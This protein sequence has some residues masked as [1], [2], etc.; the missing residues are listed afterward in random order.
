MSIASILATAAQS[1][2]AELS[3]DAIEDALTAPKNRDMGDVA[4]PCFLL[5]KPLRKGP[6]MIAAAMLEVVTPL[7]E[8]DPA[9]ASVE[10]VGPYLNFRYDLAS[11]TRSVLSAAVSADYG[12]QALGAGQRIG[13]DFSSPNIAKPF[14][15][16]HLR[17]T[18]IGAA[19]ARIYEALGYEVVRINH[20]GDWGTQF[21]KLMVA[22]EKWGDRAVLEADPIQHLY[23]LYVR[24]HV[25]AKTDE[26]LNDEGR[27]WFKKLEDG[28]AQAK[29][30]WTE[31]RDLSMRE[32]E[33][34]YARLNVKFDHYWGEAFYNEMLEDVIADVEA[35]GL[36][37][38][39]E[40]ALVVPMTDPEMPPCLLRKQDGA[41][42]YATRDLAAARYRMEE[43]KLN[44]LLYVVGTAQTVHFRQVFEVVE[45]MGWPFASGLEHI[46]FGMILGMS[47]RKGTLVFLEQILDEG[48]A[49]VLDYLASKEDFTDEERDTI[50]E[51]IAIGAVVFSDLS[52]NRVVDYDFSWE[53]ML[54]GL[55]PGERGQTGVYLQYTNARLNSVRD[56][57]I[58]Q[59]GSVPTPSDD[60]YALLVEP[61]AQALIALL[62]AWPAAV[63]KAG[64]GAEPAVISRYALRLAEAFNGFY[65][66]GTKILSE[67]A[68][69]T[70]VRMALVD[71]TRNALSMALGLLGIATPE[72]I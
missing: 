32:F 69:E 64:E 24:F 6:P 21:G 62:E 23:D 42:L 22:F 1:L 17:S 45:R 28:D 47:T 16:G 59:L 43:L 40:G 60:N 39:S 67:D 2:G 63:Q 56:K 15:V 52:R 68:G 36:A 31:F 41:T 3:V 25:D 14:G 65:S 55:Q 35:K 18:A 9:L 33:R 70:A 46:P 34:I 51:Q 37:E 26:S 7:V 29:A 72:R 11:R 44:R 8:A 61:E 20:L 57:C 19:I 5:A 13:I 30:Y 48:K 58:A 12:T 10:A 49:R 66:S 50:A 54:K 53:A 71:A 38:V 4:F 27:A